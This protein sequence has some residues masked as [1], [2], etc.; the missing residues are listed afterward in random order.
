MDSS[1]F[2]V[3][4]KKLDRLESILLQHLE[5]K[6]EELTPKPPEQLP[7]I[8]GMELAE[9]MTGLKRSTIYKLTSEGK[10]PYEKPGGKLRFLTSDL[11]AWVK[12]NSIND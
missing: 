2:T 9:L 1:P 12:R 4:E 6:K 5:N 11:L 3:I 10:I 7:P 8:G